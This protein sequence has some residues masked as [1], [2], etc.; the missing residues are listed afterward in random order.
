MQTDIPSES[1]P[2][3]PVELDSEADLDRFVDAHD[4]VLVDFYTEGCSLCAGLEPVLGNVARAHGD[5][6]V[7]TIN[8]RDDP[9]SIERFGI[10][11]VPTLVHFRDG[12]VVGR[13]AE[14]FQGGDAIDAFLAETGTGG[15]E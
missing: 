2:D 11:S 10:T 4:R 5:L 1:A 14:G 15:S 12:A 7:A 13:L 9:A 8:P 6:A 3:R